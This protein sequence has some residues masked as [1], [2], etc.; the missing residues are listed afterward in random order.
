M[1]N[2]NKVPIEIPFTSDWP[3]RINISLDVSTSN[4][5][6]FGNVDFKLDTGSDFVTI[7]MDD[8]H[9]LG[10]TDEQLKSCPIHGIATTADGK[11]VNLQYMTNVSIKYK[12]R[13]IQQATIYFAIGT[14][15]RNLLGNNWLKYFDIKIKRK[16]SLL[17][18]TET[19]E[20]PELTDGEIPMQI[21]DLHGKM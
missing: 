8:L 4:L 17:T 7:N 15:M 1:V 12:N 13:E 6:G 16:S 20:P 5:L 14:K 11:K 9:R 3:G 19:T 18:L 21:Y 10:Y 2:M